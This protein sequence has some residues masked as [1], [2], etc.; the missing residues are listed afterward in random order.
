M[1]VC[2]AL[3][4]PHHFP[5]CW[6]PSSLPRGRE[7]DFGPRKSKM[8][9]AIIQ[10]KLPAAEW[11]QL[12][13]NVNCK[14]NKASWAYNAA[15]W[16]FT[17]STN[18][19]RIR[20]RRGILKKVIFPCLCALGIGNWGR[21]EMS[22]T[23]HGEML[24]LHQMGDQI[25]SHYCSSLYKQSRKGVDITAGCCTIFS[26]L[27]PA[28]KLCRGNKWQEDCA[29]LQHLSLANNYCTLARI[30]YLP[31]PWRVG[32][33]QCSYFTGRNWDADCT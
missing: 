27:K 18:Q 8:N 16:N 17:L 29:C 23:Q 6:H 14:T 12:N 2:S 4:Y 1:P 32:S 31:H 5:S 28:L 13:E 9:M 20:H 19:N 25:L 22:L 11:Q 15:G 26:S 7:C 24:P 10:I 30:S 33:M 3:P 21:R